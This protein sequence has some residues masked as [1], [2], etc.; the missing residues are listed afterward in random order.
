MD[1][2]REDEELRKLAK[3]IAE[4]KIGFYIHLTAYVLVN[5]MLWTIWAVNSWGSFPWPLFVSAFW[6]IGLFSHGL[7]AYGKGTWGQRMED[8]EYERLKYQRRDRY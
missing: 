3:E 1:I 2:D 7:S 8:R 4:E 5:L 6:G